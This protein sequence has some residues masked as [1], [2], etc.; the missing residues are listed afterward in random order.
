MQIIIGSVNYTQAKTLS[1]ADEVAGI[2]E[3]VEVVIFDGGIG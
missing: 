3:D 2:V 1:M